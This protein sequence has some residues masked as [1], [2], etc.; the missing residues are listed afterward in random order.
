VLKP[1]QVCNRCDGKKKI[2]MVISAGNHKSVVCDECHGKGSLPAKWI[3]TGHQIAPTPY[4]SR[5]EEHT[6]YLER[7]PSNSQPTIFISAY[8][9]EKDDIAFI[10]K[11]V[12][13]IE[14]LLNAR[15]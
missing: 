5:G 7:M 4:N 13:E 6:F 12:E 2:N 15:I 10:D 14:R 3:I 1:T 9:F 8:C 11:T